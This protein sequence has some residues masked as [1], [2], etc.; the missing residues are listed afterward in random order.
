MAFGKSSNHRQYLLTLVKMGPEQRL[1]KALELSAIT[2]ALFLSGLHKRFPD[3]TETEIKQ[4]YLQRL[5]KCYNRN[6]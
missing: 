1:Q 6:Y 5:G 4:I 2:K 3:K